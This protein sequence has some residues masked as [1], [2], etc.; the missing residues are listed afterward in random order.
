MSDYELEKN[1]VKVWHIRAVRSAIEFHVGNDNAISRKK[2]LKKIW[3]LS[4]RQMRI[5]IYQLRNDGCL[6][7]S[8]GGHGGGYWMAENS[9]ELYAFIERELKSRAYD[10]LRTAKRME[11]AG[12]REYGLQFT[13]WETKET[14]L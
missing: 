9:G 3:G 12:V 1:G 13:N 5:A 8:R 4:D 10:M 6:I 14:I 7:C 11:N 2:L